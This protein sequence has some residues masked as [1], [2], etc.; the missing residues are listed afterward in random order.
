MK[1]IRSVIFKR[2]LLPFLLFYTVCYGMAASHTLEDNLSSR[3]LLEKG[4]RY[5]KNRE[6]SDSAIYVLSDIK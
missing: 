5:S 3:E 2:L 6:T 4:K 1:K